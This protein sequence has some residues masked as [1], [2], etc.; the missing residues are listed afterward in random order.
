MKIGIPEVDLEKI[1][2][3]Y[4]RQIVLDTITFIEK[5]IRWVQLTELKVVRDY[6]NLMADNEMQLRKKVYDDL[7]KLGRFH[8]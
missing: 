8:K 6:Q 1:S 2:N 4:K 7:M 5:Y 3:D